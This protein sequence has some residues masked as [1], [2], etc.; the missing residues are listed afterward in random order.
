MNNP[1]Q[2]HF[3]KAKKAKPSPKTKVDLKKHKKQEAQSTKSLKTVEDLR[4][5]LMNRK[6]NRKKARAVSEK[7][8]IH[9]LV[10][11]SLGAILCTLGLLYT[12]KIDDFISRVEVG[13]FT[14]ALAKEENPAQENGPEKE[15]QSVSKKSSEPTTKMQ[16]T[17]EQIS[18][19]NKLRERKI[20]LDQR[21]QELAKLEEELH[22]Q[23][24]EIEKRIQELSKMRQDIAKVLE[25]KVSVD[26]QKITKLVDFYSNMKP[27]SAA[28]VIQ[29]IDEDLAVE[30]LGKMKKK[31]A[32]DIMNLLKPEKA[33]KLTEKFAGYMR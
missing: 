1:Y 23:K 30:I 9:L 32:A 14:K 6:N 31:N 21:E 16:W 28:K 25:N 19:F 29:D 10:A 8:P 4:N 20:E 22:Q 13:T 17:R 24:S 2:E 5:E 11:M 7:Q 15:N 3:K 18:N 26:E 33:Q 27:V 12:D